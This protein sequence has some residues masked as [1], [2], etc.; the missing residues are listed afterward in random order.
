ML[1]EFDMWVDVECV[2]VEV[3][4]DTDMLDGVAVGPSVV[5]MM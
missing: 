2:A 1:A 4:I 5:F 3:I